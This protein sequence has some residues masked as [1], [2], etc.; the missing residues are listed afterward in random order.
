MTM[1]MNGIVQMKRLWAL[2]LSILVL[3]ACAPPAAPGGGNGLTETATLALT[4][5][6]SFEVADGVP[7]EHTQAA[8]VALSGKTVTGGTIA[9]A[10]GDI[11][12]TPTG[13]PKSRP[14]AQ[15]ARVIEI[16]VWIGTVDLGDGVCGGGVGYGPFRVTLD[17]NDM[18]INVAPE[19]VPL[20]Q[21]TIDLLDDFLLCIEVETSGINATINIA[22]LT[23]DLE[24]QSQGAEPTCN[25]PCGFDDGG[26]E[27]R[28]AAAICEISF[29]SNFGSGFA[30]ST[31]DGRECSSNAQCE[32][33][34]DCTNNECVGAV[35]RVCQSTEVSGCT[36]GAAPVVRNGDSIT[37]SFDHTILSSTVNG[38]SATDEGTTW[39]AEGLSLGVQT[40]EI[41][42]QNRI[43]ANPARGCH[44]VQINVVE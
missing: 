1:D 34:D 14:T 2:G 37:I 39:I 24:T 19:S 13:E 17:E 10:P 26:P 18:P 29:P 38:T 7:V 25:L 44:R 21:E 32:D 27:G 43:G 15:G 36:D 4:D 40:L 12:V 22:K 9:V 23:L 30:G 5:A 6:S 41:E 28:A 42:W 31:T 3:P 35:V 20:V 33:G 8:S 16:T 11:T